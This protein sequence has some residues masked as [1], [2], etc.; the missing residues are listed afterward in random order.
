M[1]DMIQAVLFWVD[2]GGLLYIIVFVL[3]ATI[4]Y[5]ELIKTRL[6]PRWLSIWGLISAVVLLIASLLF[7]LEVLAAEM[8]VLLMITLALQEQV[9]AI[10]MIVKGFDTSVILS[11][12]TI[13]G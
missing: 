9:M 2:S 13:G 3:G 8:A 5:Y 11:E 1:G 4:F 10:W 7:Y 6:V 12:S